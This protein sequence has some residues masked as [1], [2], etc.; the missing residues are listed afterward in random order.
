MESEHGLSTVQRAAD[1]H[2]CK[3]AYRSLRESAWRRVAVSIRVQRDEHAL[4]SV[5]RHYSHLAGLS[6]AVYVPNESLSAKAIN[7]GPECHSRIRRCTRTSLAD[8]S[9]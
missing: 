5:C 4:S 6:V 9:R 1:I 8:D 7:E 2:G 3:V